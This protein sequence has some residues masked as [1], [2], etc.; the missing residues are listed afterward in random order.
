MRAYLL[1]LLTLGFQ[2]AVGQTTKP[3]ASTG[4]AEFL[5]AGIAAE[6]HGDNRT[7]IEDFRKALALQP[8]MAEAHAGL[9]E[10]LAATGQLDEAIEQDLLAL[11]AAAD[12]TAV[13]MNLATAYLKKNDLANARAQ[14]EALHA[15]APGD[16][17]A[18]VLLGS[19]YIRMG[20]E[21]EAVDLLTPLEPG[22]ETNMELEY[23]L[24]FSLI[25]VGKDEEGVPRMEK[26]AQ[27]KH[28]ASAYVVAGASHLHKGEMVG[29][30]TDLDAA[31]SIDPSI[32]GLATMAG[33]ARYAMKEMAAATAAFQVALRTN[34]AD[35]TA[36]L[37]LGAIRLAEGDY[38]NA[39]PL[40]EL[41]LQL[42]PTLPLARIEVAKLDATTGHYSEAAAILEGLVK[43]APN[44]VDAHWELASVYTELNR[45]ADSRR[46]RMVAQELRAKALAASGDHN[47]P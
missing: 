33:Q 44:W 5:R 2:A 8:K 11:A 14:G 45:P 37:D 3:A 10:A 30:R 28:L 23:V 27:A 13:R 16:V 34:P 43:D 1:M 32:P 38:A 17:A 47:T 39:R 41:A 31:M 9:G 19:V 21:G 25:Q 12:K 18:A 24:A 42:Q 36:N 35:P 4:A 20:R 29:A 6:Q 46:E 22:H 7:A 26:V 40:L 15:A